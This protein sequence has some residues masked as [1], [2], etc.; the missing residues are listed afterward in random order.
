[1]SKYELKQRGTDQEEALA[2]QAFKVGMFLYGYCGGL[3]G[4]HYGAKEILRIHEDAILVK[5]KN[6][7]QP[8]LSQPIDGYLYTW[9]GLL[10][11]SNDACDGEGYEEA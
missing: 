6:T 4:D 3:F 7:D 2:K 1:M 8:L 5:V 10:E 9:V 11:D